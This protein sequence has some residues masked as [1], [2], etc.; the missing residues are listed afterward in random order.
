MAPFEEAMRYQNFIALFHQR[1]DCQDVSCGSFS[2]TGTVCRISQ[3]VKM[4]EGGAKL[5]LEGISRV[6]LVMLVQEAPFFLGQVEPVREFTEKSV[7]SE[8]LMQ[9][10]NALLK[11]AFPMAGPCPTTF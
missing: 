4:A 2:D 6:K 7:V 9:S 8:A 10:L 1:E 5:S 3:F 11:I